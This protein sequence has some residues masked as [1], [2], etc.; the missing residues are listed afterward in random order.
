MAGRASIARVVVPPEAV[1]VPGDGEANRCIRIRFA[2]FG[3][4]YINKSGKTQK[5]EGNFQHLAEE[6]VKGKRGPISLRV[7]KGYFSRHPAAH[8][9]LKEPP[10]SGRLDAADRLTL[11]KL[12]TIELRSLKAKKQTAR[13]NQLL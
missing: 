1:P 2:D 7:I 9:Y 13:E 12:R 5:P 8:C 11:L 6:K 3:A 4:A 10:L